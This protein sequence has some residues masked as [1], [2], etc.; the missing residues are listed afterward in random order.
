[1]AP[2]AYIAPNAEEPFAKLQD[3]SIF[4]KKGADVL[5]FAV[6]SKNGH[7]TIPRIP[8][9]NTKE[10]ER[11]YAK[12]HL[13]CAFR[14]FAAN[15]F[16]EGLSG[17]MSL[18]DPVEPNTFWINPY[19]M[20]FADITVSDLV[21]VTEEAEVIDGIHSVNAA[22]FAIHSEI[23]RA[24]PWVNA[25]CHAHS[26]AGKAFSVFGKPVAPLMQDALKFYNRQSILH[27]YHGPVLNTD[28]GK[29]IAA[30][31]HEDTNMV[32][33]RNHGLL[34]IGTTID[35][36]CYWFTAFDRCC[37][38]QLLID[39]ASATNGTPRPIDEKTAGLDNEAGC[40]SN[41]V[42]SA[43]VAADTASATSKQSKLMT[44]EERA[45]ALMRNGQDRPL[46]VFTYGGYPLSGH[47]TKPVTQVRIPRFASLEDEREWRKLHHA[48]ALRWLGMNG[49]NNEGA[50]GHVTVRDPILPNHFW[51]NPHGVSFSYMRPQD[52]CLVNENGEVV[53]PGNMH[54]INPAGFSIHV[55]VHM[56]RPDVVAACH[57]HSVPSKA[58]SA[59]GCTLEPINQD[60]CRFYEDHSIYESFGG[61]VLAHEEGQR[62]AKALGKNKAVILSSHG[63]L[64][65]AKTVDAATFLFG[66]M[67]RCIQ[68]QLLADAAAAGRGT[69]TIKVSHEAAQF[70]H[71]VPTD[72]ME[73][74][75]F[76]SCFEDVVRASNGE[77]KMH[78]PGELPRTD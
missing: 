52:L 44:G 45:Q 1:M 6:G 22:G 35:E 71:R 67:D 59:L 74:V 66:A 50:G 73:Y 46:D 13:A 54:A 33:L 72:E 19:S 64:T 63:I 4:H 32:I 51:I 25:V 58:F 11:Q 77:L 29:A 2:T 60:A 62:I 14:V 17:H 28:E 76:Q 5:N 24:H 38:A 41:P 8:D 69:P 70:T 39:A 18:R 23:H 78:V 10:E 47:Q 20:H 75:M 55:A 9:F 61:A 27:E 56:A 40:I 34:S 53:E 3:T 30:V 49:Y 16:D 37:Q 21:R 42:T 31:I 15:G 12:E 36:A 43:P 65:V 68:A 7:S 26:T 48:A 57:C